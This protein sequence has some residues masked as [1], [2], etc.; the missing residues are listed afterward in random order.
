MTTTSALIASTLRP[1]INKWFGNYND[2]PSEWT[3]IYDQYTSNM[4]FEVDVEMRLFGAGRVREEGE[5]TQF[6]DMGEGPKYVYRH[7]EVSTGYVMTHIAIDD[8]LYASQFPAGAK[9]LKSAMLTTKE[10]FGA[11]LL[12]NALTVNGGDGVPM[13]SPVHPILG[14]TVSNTPVVA[15][16]LS[17][18][19]LLDSVIRISRFKD[20]A[21]LPK[22]F[23]PR[24]LVISPEMEFIVMRLFTTQGRVGT[25]DKDA[26]VLSRNFP[27]G[28]VVNHY[29]KNTN[30][31]FVLTDAE[32]GLKYFSRTPLKTKVWSDEYTDN[33]LTSATERYS[34]G[35]SN[36]RAIDGSVA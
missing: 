26:A 20:A 34:F 12:N 25:A 7:I 9:A 14:G 15:T 16:Q 22:P 27:Q 35:R 19:A 11:D 5:S 13:L 1:G 2:F 24:K 28:Y 21:G 30:A 6:Q 10:I 31:W 8:N 36:F 3:E 33:V 32:D 18:S 23:K 17:E 4:G 29:I